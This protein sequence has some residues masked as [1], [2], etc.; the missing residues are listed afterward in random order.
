[1]FPLVL[2]V[3]ATPLVVV[4]LDATTPVPAWAWGGEFC[5]VTRTADELS[6]VCSEPSVPPR[7]SAR[8]RWRAFRVQGPLD[9]SMI[10][11]LLALADPLARED[12][13]I[14]A[15]STHDTDY[16]LVREADLPRACVA[17]AEAGHTLV[18]T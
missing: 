18:D 8:Q 11:V 13:S 9:F 1:M 7:D 10:G 2:T 15:I 6:V 5:S 4:R 17:L 3:L 12:V 14:F 16:V